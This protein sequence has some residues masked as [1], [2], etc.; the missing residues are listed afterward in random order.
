MYQFYVQCLNT[1]QAV[2]FP[3]KGPIFY[4]FILENDFG[5]YCLRKNNTKY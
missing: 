1:K 2:Y 3:I 5:K 4:I